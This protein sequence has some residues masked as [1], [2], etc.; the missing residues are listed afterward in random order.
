MNIEKEILLR[1]IIVSLFFLRNYLP[2]PDSDELAY[3]QR[4]TVNITVEYNG[5]IKKP[6]LSG[7]V[8]HNETKLEHLQIFYRS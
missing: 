3:M 5:T 4:V 6:M 2:P 8:L 7:Y 1:S